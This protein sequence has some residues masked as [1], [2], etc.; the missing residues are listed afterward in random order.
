[1][2]LQSSLARLTRLELDAYWGFPTVELVVFTGLLSVA[3]RLET[4]SG[5]LNQGFYGFGI[6]IQILM[7]GTITPR[8]FAGSINRREMVVL[9]SY[10]TK[11]WKILLSKIVVSFAVPFIA[12]SLGVLLNTYL[13]GASFL[14][15]APYVLMLV[16]AIQVLYWCSLSMFISI[17]LKNEI[18]SVFVFLLFMFGLELNPLTASGQFAYLTQLRSNMVMYGSILSLVQ[19]S[20]TLS[21]DF[22]IAIGFPLLVSFAL[23]LLAIAYFE[24][25]MQLD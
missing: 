16:I 13:F 14:T 3:N 22:G 2:R 19:G 21:S 10:P 24:K 9:L 7:I 5:Q 17:M 25:V 1:M 12:L 20:G 8:T 23:I 11:R 18:V 4:G 6:L 15:F